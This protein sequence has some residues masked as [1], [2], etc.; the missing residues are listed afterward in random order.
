M[1]DDAR[2][3][4]G[5]DDGRSRSLNTDTRAGVG[6]TGATAATAL[7]ARLRRISPERAGAV[8]RL[9]VAGEHLLREDAHGR[10]DLRNDVTQ[11]APHATTAVLAHAHGRVTL[12]LASEHGT[13]AVGDRS[14]HDFEGDARLLA[15]TLAYEPLI[16]RLSD[17]LGLPLLPVELKPAPESS[18]D[19][20]HWMGF[21]YGRGEQFH[22]EGLF[23]LDRTATEALSALADWQRNDGTSPRIELEHV[24]LPCRLSLAPI[25]LPTA[26]L[27]AIGAGDVVV[28]GR[29]SAV[30]DALRLRADTGEPATDSRHAWAARAAGD[31]IA[32]ARALTEAELRNEAIMSDDSASLPVETSGHDDAD[33]RDAI[34]IRVELVL[35]ELKLTLAELGDLGAG[36]ML[37]LNQPVE[38][39]RVTLRANG[40]IIGTGELIALGDMLG[41]KVT[42]I[43]DARG[44]Q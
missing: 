34:P 35:D 37:S 29:R 16:S 17:L 13:G 22:C 43:G 14:W 21:R 39:A 11:A 41:L 1:N 9:L 27:R 42:R 40:R 6:E 2:Y 28:V 32:I 5:H 18:D 24:P 19:V 25:E 12:V 7:G 30:L 20:W 3:R 26:T 23:G 44:L 31:G 8:T 38:N 4:E 36:Q 15:W 10:L 33:P